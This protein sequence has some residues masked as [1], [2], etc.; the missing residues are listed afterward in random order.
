VPRPEGSSEHS[1]RF[2]TEL[3]RYLFW[4]FRVCDSALAAARRP[5]GLVAFFASALPAALAARGLVRPA[6]PVWDSALAAAIFDERAAL[7]FARVLPAALAAERPVL[8]VFL[9]RDLVQRNIG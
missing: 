3:D 1:L 8:R 6:R 7:R 4:R 2:A 9:K 5:V